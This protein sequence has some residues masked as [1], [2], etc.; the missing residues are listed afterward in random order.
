MQGGSLAGGDL[1]IGLARLFLK[2]GGLNK[3]RSKDMAADYS[4][5]AAHKSE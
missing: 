3:I 5:G 1:K 2:G 4:K